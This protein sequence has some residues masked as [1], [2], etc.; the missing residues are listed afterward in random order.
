VL[1]ILYG[2]SVSLMAQKLNSYDSIDPWVQRLPCF[3]CFPNVRIWLPW[4]WC[5]I[6]R[7][8]SRSVV[9]LLIYIYIYIYIYIHT[10]IYIYI[11]F[12]CVRFD[13]T[14]YIWFTRTWYVK[15]Q[16]T[17]SCQHCRTSS[18]V[19]SKPA[20]LYQWNYRFRIILYI[21]LVQTPH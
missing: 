9:W 19:V 13:G 15:L 20:L 1:Q 2:V 12:L 4:G 10:R 14:V 21:F 18:S 3:S 7:N 8:M 11:K 16:F 17:Y 5:Q 6:H